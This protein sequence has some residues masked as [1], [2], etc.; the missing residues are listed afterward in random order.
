MRAGLF[1]M[2]L[3]CEESL[4][5]AGFEGSTGK[6]GPFSFQFEKLLRGVEAEWNWE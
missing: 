6:R 5:V 3:R 1:E 4:A 2:V